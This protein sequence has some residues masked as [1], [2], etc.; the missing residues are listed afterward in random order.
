MNFSPTVKRYET[1]SL[2]SLKFNLLQWSSSGHRKL[3]NPTVVFCCNPLTCDEKGQRWHE[4]ERPPVVHECLCWLVSSHFAPPH[5][6]LD[7]MWPDWVRMCFYL[8]KRSRES[9]DCKSAL[10]LTKTIRTLCI[11]LNQNEVRLVRRRTCRLNLDE[12]WIF[13]CQI[14][15]ILLHT[16]TLFSSSH[17]FSL[18]FCLPHSYCS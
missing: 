17:S 13:G 12:E 11:M 6:E 7:V 15:H 1:L 14:S 16:P 18:K 10:P 3:S 4:V 5:R 2:W 9:F 8:I